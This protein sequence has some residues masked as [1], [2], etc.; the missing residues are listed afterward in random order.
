MKNMSIP[1]PDF[2]T[3]IKTS[4]SSITKL[5]LNLSSRDDPKPFS[6]QIMED[7]VSPHYITPNITFFFG[8][9]DPESHLK[10][11]RAQMIIFGW[12]DAI[13]CK[14]F[15]GTITG[16]TLQW[17]SG[18][19]D[20]HITYFPQFSK[21]FK[22]QFSANK[23][24]PPRLY[25]LF[26]IKQREE[27]LLNEYLNR[28]CVVLVRIQT[29][30]EE[31]VVAAFIQRMTT[32]PFSD[33]LIR[34]P[35]ETLSKVRGPATTHIEVEKV[36]LKKNGSSRSKQP[37][38]KENSRDQHCVLFWDIETPSVRQRNPI[39]QPTVG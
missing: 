1:K 33:S 24:N 15:M 31:M 7:L 13:R 32:S 8:I 22:E 25:D 36:V 39:C 28:F 6:Q 18:I 20:G 9:E 30:D 5:P 26:N 14:M 23:V 29:Q 3:V 27:E 2:L 37:R 21:M 10:A 38:H 17:F 16:T 11:F 12:S 19:P 35:A 34:N 4:I